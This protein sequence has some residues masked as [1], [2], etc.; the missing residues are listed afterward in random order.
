MT[1]AGNNRKKGKFDSRKSQKK[2]RNLTAKIKEKKDDLIAKNERK[3]GKWDRRSSDTPIKEQEIE[4]I[5]IFTINQST[6]DL[7]NKI[8]K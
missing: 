8:I 1:T 5:Y 6:I 7:M 4:D 3:K 2:K